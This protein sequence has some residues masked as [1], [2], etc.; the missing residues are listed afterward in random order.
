MTPNEK[1]SDDED[2][3]A[4]VEL[5]D[6]SWLQLL[7]KDEDEA[8]SLKPWNQVQNARKLDL[9]KALRQYMRQAWSK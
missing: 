1:S 9:A 5:V 7:I 6:D 8:Y 2:S 4:P 3:D